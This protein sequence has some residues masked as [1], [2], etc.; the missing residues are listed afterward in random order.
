MFTRFR[1]PRAISCICSLLCCGI[2]FASAHAATCNEPT[3]TQV[4]ELNF[5]PQPNQIVRITLRPAGSVIQRIIIFKKAAPDQPWESVQTLEDAGNNQVQ[6]VTPPWPGGDL[7]YSFQTCSGNGGSWADVP[8]GQILDP[9][10]TG[11]QQTPGG[12]SFKLGF[13]V[14]PSV[15]TTADVDWGASIAAEPPPGPQWIQ[16]R[17]GD[18][19]PG[20]FVS[21]GTLRVGLSNDPQVAVCRADGPGASKQ[22]G[23]VNIAGPGNPNIP[24]G[25]MSSCRYGYG[26]PVQASSFEILV[27]PNNLKPS[28]E[29]PGGNGK[30]YGGWENG[31]Q[32]SPCLFTDKRRDSNVST[33]EHWYVFLGKDFNW[34]CFAA[35]ETRQTR[36]GSS[37][38]QVLHV[39][40]RS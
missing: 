36:P 35:G 31:S 5:K 30:F 33:T 40:P 7:A 29:A 15:L 22:L 18:K 27:L 19:A 23:A 9:A 10:A 12:A 21:G 6:S 16:V 26:G 11:S 32:H 25:T 4:Y 24:Q 8:V 38:Y 1:I 14:Q 34:S 20:G 28:W 17:E 3:Q 37:D 13:Y 39:V 2:L